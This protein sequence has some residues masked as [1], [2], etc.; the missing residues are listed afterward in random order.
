[1]T[2]ALAKL[3]SY[4][5]KSPE[6]FTKSSRVG[7]I[8]RRSGVK[9]SAE[10]RRIL[11]LP[12]REWSKDEPGFPELLADMQQWLR[13]PQGTMVLR[14]VQAKALAEMHDYGGLFGP[15]Q[16]GSGKAQPNT[17][18]VLLERGWTP[19]GEVRV[20]DRIY[21]SDGQLH[22]V[23]GVFPQGMRPV[24]RITFSGGAYALCDPG[25]LWTLHRT[26]CEDEKRTAAEW[27]A[28]DFSIAHQLPH[29]TLT[30]DLV[31][32]AADGTERP[33]RIVHYIDDTGTNAEMTC[34]SVDAP[35]QLYA[36]RFCILTH[37]TAVSL[38][39]PIVL[40]AKRPLLILPAKLR[41]KTIREIGNYQRHFRIV[42]PAILSYEIL[43][44]ENGGKLL[45]EVAPDLIICDETHRIK[46]KNAS[47]TRKI[48]T[49]MKENPT[50]KFVAL[51]GT[52]TMRSLRDYAHIIRWCLPYSSPLPSTQYDLEEWSN[53][54][55]EKIQDMQRLSVGALSQLCEP[56]DQQRI[57]DAADSVALSLA[58]KAYQRRL[59]ETPGV[60][61]TSESLLGASLSIS[62]VQP[63]LGSALDEAFLK[64]R[65]D[66]LTPDDHPVIDGFQLWRHARELACG[67]YYRWNPRPPE[68]W[69]TARRNW[70]RFARDI[71]SMHRPGLD[72]ELPVANACAKGDLP[73]TE[74]LA[75]REIRDTF[76]PNQ[77][78]VWVSD[79]TLRFAA[80]WLRKNDG[81][82]WV[83]HIAFGERLAELTG[84]SYYG[85]GGLD[86][87]KRMIEDGRGPCIAS[88]AANAEGRNL[89]Q[90]NKSLVVSCPPSGKTW[91]QCLDE[92]TEVLTEEGWKGIDD[93]ITSKVAAYSISDGSIHWS[94]G[95]RVERLLGEEDMFGISNPHLDIR[96]T[97]GHRMVVQRMRRFG[98][99]GRDGFVYSPREFIEAAKMPQRAR[100]PLAGVQSAEGVPLSDAE[101]TFIGLFMSDGNLSPKNNT[102]ALFQST[103][104]PDIIA[105]IEKTLAELDF[106]FGHSIC[107]TPSNYGERKHPLH[108][109][110]MS[111]GM[112]RRTKGGTGWGRLAPYIDKEMPDTLDAMTREQLLVFLHGLWLGDGSKTPGTYDYDRYTPGT[113]N[114]ATRRKS[115]ADKVQSLCIRRGLRCNIS[116]G[117]SVWML[118]ISEDTTWTVTTLKISDGRQR[119]GVLPS[120]T[121]ERVWCVSV[122]SGAIVTRRNGKV[123]VVGNCLGRTHR[124]GQEADE[125]SY[126]VMFACKE[127]MDG[128]L[129]A[130]ADAR[131]LQD[132]LGSPQ[133][134]LYA[135]LV[136]DMKDTIGPRW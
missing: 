123:A 83:E 73:N 96:V 51:S 93:S 6:D 12:R 119:W 9:D 136:L 106:R 87:Q 128:F 46:N 24:W 56:A 76:V 89:Q 102:L 86:K 57:H 82:C 38:L 34:I 70:A 22:A 37:N 10:L 122:D 64:L 5:G 110:T 118:R 40:E 54:L 47:V 21:G 33:S 26:A 39:A 129:Q 95:R 91:E 101:L 45:A 71:L 124:E 23:T 75:W 59:T 25:H 135:D 60:V 61:A 107:T 134:L 29:L 69:L 7:K 132:T 17:E 27:A 55:D 85:G 14:P 125:V 50:T 58:R 90:W 48:S 32:A 28:E 133:K 67:F 65:K 78:A 8:F 49:W 94:E 113:Q 80:E 42:P 68:E 115:V 92:R 52:I 103:R 36:T 112:P 31:R 99:G 18:P 104:Y 44:R 74:Y 98:N 53:A 116:R 63:Q 126:D 120:S 108:K 43:S 15:M 121:S 20:G 3:L 4:S 109:W 105:T 72:S 13:M 111:K 41:D 16:V 130:L 30:D 81:I 97:A 2:S 62:A 79:G 114:I 77:E 117:E 66:W 84:L 88:I 100:V 1:M 127:Q 35:D 19:I 11:A 131:Y